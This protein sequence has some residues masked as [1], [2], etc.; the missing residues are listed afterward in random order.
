MIKLAL[1]DFDNRTINF[2]FRSNGRFVV[3]L[4]AEVTRADGSFV[5]R[6]SSRG[7]NSLWFWNLEAD[8]TDGIYSD[9]LDRASKTLNAAVQE[10][11]FGMMDELEELLG[12]E[13]RPQP[14]P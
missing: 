5:G 13:P 7:A 2:P 10:S 4:G 12:A 11:L 8:N 1:D 3:E 14:H 6:L 9:I